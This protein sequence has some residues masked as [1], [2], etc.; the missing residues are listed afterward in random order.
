SGANKYIHVP[1]IGS[2][3]KPASAID[4]NTVLTF[5]SYSDAGY[6]TEVGDGYPIVVTYHWIDSDDMTLLD[7]DDFDDGTLQDWVKS[8]D[9][10]SFAIDT[11]Y[12]LDPLYSAKGSKG[13]G[14]DSASGT[15]YIKKTFDVPAATRAFLIANVKFGVRNSD[16]R[17]HAQIRELRIS[18]AGTII[19]RTGTSPYLL[20]VSDPTGTFYTNWLR[21]IAPID[22]NE[23]AEYRIEVVYSIYSRGSG[24]PAFMYVWHDKLKVVYE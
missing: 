11:A 15:A 8:A 10:A 2:R 1:S 9:Y 21:M 22:V 20:S 19:T 23:S 3:D 17:D 7:E 12:V 24:D 18:K 5:R 14:D 13:V 16:F 4:D 6:T